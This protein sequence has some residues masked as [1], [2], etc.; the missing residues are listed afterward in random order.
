MEDFLSA[1][2]WMPVLALFLPLVTGLIVKS[3]ASDRFKVL[4]NIVVTALY[5]L[6]EAIVDGGGVLHVATAQTWAYALVISIASYYGVWKPAGLG[7][8]G[9]ETGLG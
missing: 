6:T 5:S 8:I 4:A 3:S 9:K 7:N 2:S 1:G